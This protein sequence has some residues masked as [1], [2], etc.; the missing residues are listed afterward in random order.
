MPAVLACHAPRSV[1]RTY[2]NTGRAA[3]GEYALWLTC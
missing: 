1:H 3:C 2:V